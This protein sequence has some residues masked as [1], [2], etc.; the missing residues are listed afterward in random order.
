MNAV[1]GW[2]TTSGHI[3]LPAESRKAA[4]LYAGGDAVV[5]LAG[6]EI[7]IRTVDA[8]VARVQAIAS[9]VWVRIELVR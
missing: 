9:Q 6:D 7:R 4:G 2:V 8:V 3:S 5:E 1:H